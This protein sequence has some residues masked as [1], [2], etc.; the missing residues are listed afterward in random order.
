MLADY[1]P[2][3][4]LFILATAVAALLIGHWRDFW[5]APQVVP[6]DNRPMNRG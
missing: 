2:I 1:L 5:T 4:I 6:Q 3:A